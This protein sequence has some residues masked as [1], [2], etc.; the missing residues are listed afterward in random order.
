MSSSLSIEIGRGRE[1]EK[2]GGKQ[3]KLNERERAAKSYRKEAKQQRRATGKGEKKRQ[4]GDA[5]LLTSNGREQERDRERPE[6][7]FYL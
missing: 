1:N 4:K 6:A 2:V 7:Q 3:A 5:M